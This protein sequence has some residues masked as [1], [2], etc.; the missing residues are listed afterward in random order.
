MTVPD[1]S[2]NGYTLDQ[3][4]N[5]T[6]PSLRREIIV[7]WKKNQA[8]ANPQETEKRAHE[9]VYIVRNRS[10]DIVGVSSVYIG[11]FMQPGKRYYFCRMF[12]QPTD[13]IAGMMRFV[14]LQTLDALQSVNTSDKPSGM[15][16][17]T[18]NQKLMRKGM[19]CLFERIGGQY[20]GRGP[21]GNDLWVWSF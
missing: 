18:E 14:F 12:I 19:R 11:D 2:Y 3:V 8:I 10:N 16:V 4:Y 13:R 15:V 17:V 5:K 9:V 21:R 1:H 7:F 20:F 6:T